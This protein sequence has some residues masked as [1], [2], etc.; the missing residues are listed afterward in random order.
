MDKYVCEGDSV[1]CSMG[2]APCKIKVVSNDKLFVENKKVAT[3][4]DYKIPSISGFGMCKS[5]SNPKVE[6]ATAAANGVLQPQPCEPVINSSWSGNTK[7][8]AKGIMAITDKSHNK[9]L[10]AGN[11][12]VSAKQ[13][14][15][16]G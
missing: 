9:C 3:V 4:N 15:V 7:L 12:S 10:Y 5:M 6:A 2:S 16:K 1:N 11:L 14:K 8:C 13:N